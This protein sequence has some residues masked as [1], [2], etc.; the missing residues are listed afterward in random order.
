MAVLV[1]ALLAAMA[2]PVLARGHQA[3]N[4]APSPAQAG[5]QVDILI[6]EVEP[7]VVGPDTPWTLRGSVRNAG[8]VSTDL[9]EV[10]ASTAWVALDT[11]SALDAWSD[12]END[13]RT[14]RPLGDDVVEEVLAPGEDLDFE[15]SVPG[16]ALS[17]PFS[18]T[19]LPLRVK[20]ATADG[21]TLSETRTVLPW[22]SGAPAESPLG[23]SWVVPLTVPGD[24]A[25]TSAPAPGRTQ[26]WLDAVGDES[27]ARAWLDELSESSATFVVD[28]ALLTPL[29]SAADVSA[30]PSEEPIPLPEPTDPPAEPTDPSSSADDAPDSGEESS[31][32]GAGAESDQESSSATASPTQ[33]ELPELDLPEE[34]SVLQ[35]AEA[36]LQV[37][38][39]GLSRSQL[40]WL[41][42]SDPDVAALIDQGADPELTRDVLS[43]E[44]TPS[45]YEAERLLDRGQRGVSWPAFGTVD[46]QGMATMRDLWPGG[47]PLAT[48]LPRGAFTEAADTMGQP[49]GELASPSG[50]M[51]VLGYDVRLAEILAE[52]PGPEEDGASIQ[53]LLAHTLARYQRQPST[54]GA[55]VLAPPRDAP[56]EGD[57]VAS[58]TRAVTEAPW[59]DQVAA[60]DLLDEAVAVRLTGSTPA[61]PPAESP[62]SAARIAQ[63]EAV[64]A[65]LTDLA[66]IVP[67][68]GAAAQW[69]SVLDGLY[70]TRW[71][72]L[73]REW[74]VPMSEMESQV[75]TITGG[76]RIN[77][78]EVNF[79]AQE[80]LIQIT[81]VNELPVTVQDLQLGLE[82]GNGRLRIIEAPEAVTIGPSSR[83]TVQFR[84]EAVAAGEVPVRATLSTPGGL[85][86]GEAQDLGVQVRPTGMWIYW[87]LGG[88][89]GVIL[90]LG[91]TRA[92]RRPAP[93]SRSRQEPS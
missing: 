54:P 28:P 58:L 68:G 76:V 15:I 11:A 25:L 27:P 63:I 16:D 46:G 19:S 33:P 23:V 36:D 61:D 42:V 35:E 9:A 56:V 31:G 60:A 82:P 44:L 50:A 48:V 86:I 77:P 75:S 84:A 5:P 64:R 14:P 45:V 6:D 13:P 85:T 69:D 39:G 26:A 59:I 55:V 29:G 21:S 34:A 22:Y 80:G 4:P 40:W 89:A 51:P 91:L 41:P 78:T 47:P 10:S 38:L 70:S 43:R 74:L 8:T 65:T 79:L 24:P 3:A 72:G 90:I 62:V 52:I 53:L 71:R 7:A 66:E 81:V 32:D 12:G 37:R 49:A 83:A 73:S 92:I 20:V 30:A 57:T 93:G 87:L 2:P 1:L 67:Q 88:L 17:P 18:F